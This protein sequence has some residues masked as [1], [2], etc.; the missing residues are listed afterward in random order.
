MAPTDVER[1]RELRWE[2]KLLFD[3]V[4][5]GEHVFELQARDGGTRFIQSEN[6]HGVMVPLLKGMLERDTIPGF[7][8]MNHALK[9]RAEA[10]AL[11]AR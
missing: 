4:M 3:G 2:G 1:D 11:A 10:Q 9:Q 7:E 8:A 5:N 6:F